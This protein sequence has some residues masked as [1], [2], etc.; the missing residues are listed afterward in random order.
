MLGT[1]DSE[2]LNVRQKNI[3]EELGLSRTELIRGQFE[4]NRMQRELASQQAAMQELESQPITDLECHA[5]R[6]F[7]SRA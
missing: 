1:S 4:L 3:L 2:T 5:I 7:R 6:L